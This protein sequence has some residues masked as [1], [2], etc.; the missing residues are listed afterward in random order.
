MTHGKQHVIL[1]SPIQKHVSLLHEKRLDTRS[2]LQSYKPKKKKYSK[3]PMSLKA[4]TAVRV[5]KPVFKKEML[6]AKG[7]IQP[8]Q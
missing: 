8:P 7:V 1:Y 2:Y 5:S 3:V 4:R 6:F